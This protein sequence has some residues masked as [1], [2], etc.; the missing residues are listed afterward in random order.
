MHGPHDNPVVIADLTHR[1]FLRVQPWHGCQP[2]SMA[3]VERRKVTLA[4]D[5]RTLNAS[6]VA[7]GTVSRSGVKGLFIGNTAEAVLDN[8]NCDVLIVEPPSFTGSV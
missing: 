7:I 1:S 3:D 5:A 8:L 4:A 2:L 6:I